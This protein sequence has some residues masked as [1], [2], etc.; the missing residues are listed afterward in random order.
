MAIKSL[1]KIFKPQKIALIGVSN[2][3]KSIGG[4]VLQNLI[5]SGFEGVV[6]TVNPSLCFELFHIEKGVEL[7][8]WNY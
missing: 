7:N 5:G 8:K 6:Y 1:D 3:P 2:N 4:I